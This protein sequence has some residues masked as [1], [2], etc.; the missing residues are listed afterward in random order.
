MGS[1]RIGAV[2]DE[3]DE[4]KSDQVHA[5]QSGPASPWPM[6]PVPITAPDI[7]HVEPFAAAT[8]PIDRLRRLDYP[9]AAPAPTGPVVRRILAHGG[10]VAHHYRENE[11]TQT[12]STI[13]SDEYDGLDDAVVPTARETGFLQFALQP[14][15]KQ[16]D[17]DFDAKVLSWNARVLVARRDFVLPV[18]CIEAAE[19][20]VAH[21]NQPTTPGWGPDKPQ[22]VNLH[23]SQLVDGATKNGLAA[24][25]TDDLLG[26]KMPLFDSFDFDTSRVTVGEGLVALDPDE[27]DTS[28]HAVAVVGARK[29]DSQIIVVERNA[30]TTS[31]S[32]NTLN[33]DWLLNVY[34]SPDAFRLSMGPQFL[35]GKLSIH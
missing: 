4:A 5:S 7:A 23:M 13:S 28:L 25:L 17:W 11:D 3:R 33:S 30:G 26:E 24:N 10:E 16:D 35:L 18:S 2:A 6:P 8:R 21:S 27:P 19:H 31:G 1:E 32:T 29:T 12:L 9:A 15:E 20:I 22:P 34:D 14:G